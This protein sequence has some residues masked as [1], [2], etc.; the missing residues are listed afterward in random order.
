MAPNVATVLLLD[1]RQQ[2]TRHPHIYWRTDTEN[3]YWRT[4]TENKSF[5][6]NYLT[7]FR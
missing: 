2:A 7:S 3:I 6:L 1:A 5:L 4:D